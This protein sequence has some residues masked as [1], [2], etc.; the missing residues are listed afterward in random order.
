MTVFVEWFGSQHGLGIV[1]QQQTEQQKHQK[2]DKVA[3]RICLEGDI[4]T[5]PMKQQCVYDA[6]ASSVYIALVGKTIRFRNREYIHIQNII[7][8]KAIR[9]HYI[10]THT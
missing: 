1:V 7:S 3:E 8:L 5:N 10:Q 2:P 4:S 6:D 9:L